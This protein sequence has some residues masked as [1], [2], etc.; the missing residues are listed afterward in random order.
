MRTT[1]VEGLRRYEDYPCRGLEEI[2]RLP[3]YRALR[4]IKTT[5]IQGFKRY[6]DYPYT[7]L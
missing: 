4:D 7:G 2:S 1:P 6:Q 3:L 5:P